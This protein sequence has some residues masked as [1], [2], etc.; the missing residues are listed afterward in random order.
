MY[1]KVSFSSSSALSFGCAFRWRM[2]TVTPA[3]APT[4]PP[5]SIPLSPCLSIVSFVWGGTKKKLVRADERHFFVATIKKAN[6][7]G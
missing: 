7:T 4:A 5:N 6:A 2:C 1:W 3:V